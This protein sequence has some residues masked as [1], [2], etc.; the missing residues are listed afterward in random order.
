MD[1]QRRQRSRAPRDEAASQQQS[2]GSI[3]AEAHARLDTAN[4]GLRELRRT[5]GL[6]VLGDDGG[7]NGLRLTGSAPRGQSRLSLRRGHA[8]RRT[9]HPP[10][11]QCVRHSDRD[12][13]V[14]AGPRAVAGNV[15]GCARAARQNQ[16]LC[17]SKR[18]RRA[19]S[20]PCSFD[21]APQLPSPPPA[22][23][24]STRLHGGPR[25]ADADHRPPLRLGSDQQRPQTRPKATAQCGDRHAPPKGVR[26]AHRLSGSTPPDPV[27]PALASSL[28]RLK[29]KSDPYGQRAHSDHAICSSFNS[30]SC[31]PRARR[32]YHVARDTPSAFQGT[33]ASMLPRRRA[34]PDFSPPRRPRSA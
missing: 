6:W 25:P 24:R 5:R 4:A 27:L 31:S 18:H 11:A 22:L 13:T 10:S 21:Q 9:R 8:R 34:A 16:R 29:T 2:Q 1:R 15:K 30:S 33:A 28:T 32:R 23:D 17:R 12:R 7:Q 19:M 26:F 3:P 20:T 14:R